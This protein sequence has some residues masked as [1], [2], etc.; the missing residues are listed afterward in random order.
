MKKIK[1]LLILGVIVVVAALA[2]WI[3]H[4]VTLTKTIETNSQM[5]G[6][7]FANNPQKNIQDIFFGP[8]PRAED[9]RTIF[10]N[11]DPFWEKMSERYD[12][13]NLHVLYLDSEAFYFENP[14]AASAAALTDEQISYIASLQDR[15]GFKIGVSDLG[16]GLAK[17]CHIERNPALF[18][19]SA[20]TYDVQPLKRLIN[21]GVQIDVISIDGPFLRVLD[22]TTKGGDQPDCDDQGLGYELEYGA[23]VVSGYMNGIGERVQTLTNLY[24]EENNETANAPLPKINWVVNL[25]NWRVNEYLELPYGTV[26][27][28][29]R[30]S[31]PEVVTALKQV[32]NPPTVDG[33][34]LDYLYSHTVE[35]RF[36]K[37]GNGPRSP[38]TCPE[39]IACQAI[40]PQEIFK[41]KITETAR[42]VKTLPGSPGLSF[43]LNTEAKTAYGTG[44]TPCADA[45]GQGWNSIKAIPFLPYEDN[46]CFN[47]EWPFQDVASDDHV[48]N[49][50]E[51]DTKSEADIDQQA[52]DSKYILDSLRY[53]YLTM[54]GLPKSVT[55]DNLFFSSWHLNPRQNK[56][57]GLKLWNI[58]H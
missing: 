39:G 6:I 47:G 49:G 7:W 33:V 57:Y 19:E 31:L 22:D 28:T 55:V 11:S 38:V 29:K 14:E 54:Y 16:L 35:G 13:I 30:Y 51:V 1:N 37:A 10:E 48:W 26:P 12:G 53:Y 52:R 9:G 44:L 45:R 17:Y 21:A 32:S 42:L 36:I 58:I 15:F 4:D 8:S 56:V 2:A 34:L 20:V 23:E 25:S 3:S 18:A 41:G 46:R 5:G 43:Y 24:R 50:S 40:S 27:Q